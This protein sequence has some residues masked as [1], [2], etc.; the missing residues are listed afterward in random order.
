MFFTTVFELQ[1]QW[2]LV[3]VFKKKIALSAWML[4]CSIFFFFVPIEIESIEALSDYI[5]IQIY[6]LYQFVSQQRI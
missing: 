5:R 2:D 3:K 6:M 4:S 1:F